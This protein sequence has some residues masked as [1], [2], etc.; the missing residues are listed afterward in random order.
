M[1]VASN[2]L[3]PRY[4]A[5]KLIARG[6]M[7]E[8]YRA[9]DEV[10]GRQVAVKVLAERYAAD[11]SIGARFTREAQAAAR[12]SGRPNIVMIYD[13]GEWRG[14]P[15]IVMQY[16]AGG[17]LAER[18]AHEGA[19]PPERAVAWLEQAAAALDV[20]HRNGIVH[21]DVKPA[22]LLLD[23]GGAV[24]VGDFGIASAAGL[25]SL[26]ATGMVLGTAGYL[27][28]EQARGE[29][30]TAA[31]DRYGLAATAFEL[32]TGARP[33]QSESPT[34]EAAAQIHSAVPSAHERFR[35]LPV[36]VDSVFGRALAKEPAARYGTCAAFVD[37]LGEALR[38]EPTGAAAPTVL[39]AQR[40]PRRRRPLKRWVALGV[41][42]L[43]AAG[44]GTAVAAALVGNGTPKA[45]VTVTEPVTVQRTVTA[46][47]VAAKPPPPPPPPP[48]AEPPPPPPAAAA[49]GHALNDQ[50]YTRL[51]QGD[52]AGALPL[53]QQAVS[54]LQGTG[55]G[56]PYEAYAN[57]NLGYTL[58]QLG[59]C[60][61][62]AA[63]LDNA[64]RLEPHNK[65]VRDA[66]KDVRH[67]L[68]PGERGR[69]NGKGKHH[70]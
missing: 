55:P 67:C 68:P 35:R 32:L 60:G 45:V 30:A 9:T 69:G 34:A 7:G 48:A 14:R 52:Y 41:L 31:S 53:L 28:P 13:V 33:F 37:D 29:P 25:D 10:L 8:I 24:H 11:E 61:D 64:D 66:M 2:I 70:D 65:K 23:R 21:R 49:D 36:S 62:A 20:A 59:R 39:L 42:A 58:L 15:F 27:S 56:D 51:Q 5:P 17:S 16:L 4:R 6:G 40:P 22:N 26:T 1:A 46:R 12:L 3:P 63:P 43:A 47:A 54:S 44:A 38:P 57:Y 18:I 19:Q 50:G